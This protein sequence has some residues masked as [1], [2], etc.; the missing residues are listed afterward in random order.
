ME[1]KAKRLLERRAILSARASTLRHRMI[2]SRN[3]LRRVATKLRRV[4]AAVQRH[5][6]RQIGSLATADR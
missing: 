2:S 6:T 1:K 5:R 4:D 3:E